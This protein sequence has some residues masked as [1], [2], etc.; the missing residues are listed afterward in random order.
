[1]S[2]SAG[3]LSCPTAETTARAWRVP[4]S[5][6]VTSQTAR[7]SSNSAVATP[8]PRR[9]CGVEPALG[10]HRAQ[11]IQD[12]LPRREAAAPPARP[13]RERVQVRRHVT[14]QAGVGVVPPGPPEVVAAVD[15]E[16]V[17][18]AR[19]PQRRGHADPA[20]PGADHEN[21]VRRLLGHGPSLARCAARPGSRPGAGIGREPGTG[22][23]TEL[24]RPS[25]SPGP[26][27]AGRQRRMKRAFSAAKGPGPF[28]GLLQDGESM[29][30]V[31]LRAI[32]GK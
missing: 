22:R 26:A 18:D 12:L 30:D 29:P 14:G 7:R 2:G 3:R 13:E 23:I 1:M 10:G 11:V 17:V 8:A 24:A 21:L 9:R 27:E 4:P 19:L 20:E 5:S 28:A 32:P 31:W 25:R 6:R 15:D 16:E